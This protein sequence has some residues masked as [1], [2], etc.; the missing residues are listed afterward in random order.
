M[1]MWLS[2]MNMHLGCNCRLGVRAGKCGA[3]REPPLRRKLV[4]AVL[5]DCCSLAFNGVWDLSA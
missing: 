5:G 1:Y 3:A 4:G 2:L